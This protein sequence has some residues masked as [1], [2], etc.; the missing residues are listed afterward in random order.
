MKKRACAFEEEQRQEERQEDAEW[1]NKKTKTVEEIDLT[2]GTLLDLVNDHHQE[3]ILSA[4]QQQ[5]QNYLLE[6]SISLTND[7]IIN[8]FMKSDTLEGVLEHYFKNPS[9]FPRPI[10]SSVSESYSSSSSSSSSSSTKCYSFHKEPSL[11]TVIVK[12]KIGTV[13]EC[14][15]CF[16]DRDIAD[17]YFL[18][19]AHQHSF[20]IHCMYRQ[21]H[22]SVHPSE[23]SAGYLP[24]CPYANGKD[25]CKYVLGQREVE[26]IINRLSLSESNS[27]PTAED[28]A[29]TL[30]IAKKLYFVSDIL[31][32]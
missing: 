2:N 4:E 14:E 9:S 17:F 15:I 28:R 10:A 8:L 16:D 18:N 27:K 32:I 7:E 1:T 26:E 12:R 29:K 23:E 31:E 25:G 3:P 21:I 22:V 6:L 5:L 30:K 11:T 20:C 13:K 19:C 24:S